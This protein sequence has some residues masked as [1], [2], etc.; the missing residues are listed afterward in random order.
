MTAAARAWAAMAALGAIVLITAS[1]WALALWPVGGAA[2]EWLLRTREVCFGSTADRLPNA[3][4]WILLVGQPVSMAVVLVAVWG[5]EVREGMAR[6]MARVAGQLAI[7]MVAAAL[8]A[9]VGG[10][11]VRV[12]TAGLE[13]FETGGA[14]SSPLT[15]VNDVAPAL[16]LTD[17]AGREITLESFRGR[18]VLVTFAYAHC[19]TVCPLIVADAIAA[20]QRLGD[21]PPPVLIVTLDPWRDTPS[22]LPSIAA[23]WGLAEGSHVLSGSPEVVER[24]LNAWRVPRVRNDKTGEISHPS[25]VYVI[26]ANGR[27]TYVLN[28]NADAIAAAVRA[29]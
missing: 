2:P 10:V 18:P 16:A 14:G 1:W 15:R 17:Q 23:S 26:G 22:R 19:Q 3:G 7:G 12:R 11:V 5:T 13:P 6:A 20:R 9:G 29:L 27:I 21:A 8:V 28:G 25:I 24:A 4:G